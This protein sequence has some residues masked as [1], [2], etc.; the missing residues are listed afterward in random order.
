MFG[1]P[2]EMSFAGKSIIVCGSLYQLPRINQ[3]L[4]YAGYMDALP[5]ILPLWSMFQMA[6][7]TVVMRQRED[8]V[9]TDILN[10]IKVG[11]IDKDVENI[12]LSKFI[13]PGL[14]SYLANAI[15]IWAESAPV[16]LHNAKILN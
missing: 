3:R 1:T 15:P 13:M 9:F 10:K 8:T 5:N 2:E 4:I 16:E 7:L 11:N 6:E 12:L 14:P